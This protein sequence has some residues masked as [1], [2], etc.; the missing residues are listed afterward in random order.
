MTRGLFRAALALV[1]VGLLAGV[2]ATYAPLAEEGS[3]VASELEVPIYPG[4]EIVWELYLT[5]ADFLGW[6]KEGLKLEKPLPL[7]EV[8]YLPKR[9][10]EEPW[11]RERLL[12]RRLPELEDEDRFALERLAKRLAELAVEA[13]AG[14]EGLRAVGYLVED[15][16]PAA[17]ME[18]Y[19][20]EFTPAEGWR[21]NFWMPDGMAVYSLSEEGRLREVAGFSITPPAPKMGVGATGVLGIRTQGFLKL[22][23]LMELLFL[24]SQLQRIERELLLERL[25]ME[26]GRKKATVVPERG[27]P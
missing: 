22:R 2:T 6:L 25:E 23:P 15:V 10:Q 21:R 17:I 7:P 14:L 4:G 26:S 24:V 20:Q 9:L 16:E 13:L 12:P 18:F 1:A 3:V 8:P 19:E 27:C 5:D 11:L